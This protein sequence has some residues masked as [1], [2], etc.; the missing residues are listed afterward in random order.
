MRQPD[1]KLGQVTIEQGR[2]P[3]RLMLETQK[4]LI[5]VPS[6]RELQ[7]LYEQQK[8]GP[9]L[10]PKIAEIGLTL[11]AQTPVESRGK[12]SRLLRMLMHRSSRKFGGCRRPHQCAVRAGL[13]GAR[14]AL[15]RTAIRQ[16]V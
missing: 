12:M 5:F 13:D 10:L 3:L 9:E 4:S 11:L 2:P 15:A 14:A 1:V 8:L 16:A 6:M 7:Q